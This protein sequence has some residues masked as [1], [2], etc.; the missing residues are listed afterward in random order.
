MLL[1]SVGQALTKGE[2]TA[3]P[4]MGT[5]GTVSRD[6]EFWGRG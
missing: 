6:S 5:L 2:E 4:E 1:G 3:D